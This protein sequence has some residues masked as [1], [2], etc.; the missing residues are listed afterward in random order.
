M[1]I[2]ETEPNHAGKGNAIDVA[3]DVNH[4]RSGAAGFDHPVFKRL[5]AVAECIRVFPREPEKP[6]SWMPCNDDP[7]PCRHSA[8]FQ[9]CGSCHGGF[10]TL[11]A[12][13]L[14]CPW[15]GAEIENPETDNRDAVI[16]VGRATVIA[17]EREKTQRLLEGREVL[18]N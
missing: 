7:D 2:T 10:N 16:S 14:F 5:H 17:S 9:S 1:Q 3:V 4:E 11:D 8:F 18:D 13:A 15:C 6:A 12:A